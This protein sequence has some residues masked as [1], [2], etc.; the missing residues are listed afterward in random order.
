M[1]EAPT[2]FSGSVPENYHR[3]L[4][5]LIFEYYATD[6]A[7]RLL[8]RVPDAGA[9]LETACGTGVLTGL[10]A[11]AMPTGARLYATDLNPA[12][13]GVA[14][15]NLANHPSRERLTLQPADATAL[16][17]NNATFDALACQFGVMFY[18][19]KSL[20]YT[21]AARVL[22]PGGTL[23]FNVW[24][25][26]EHND[27]CQMTHRIAVD[28]FPDNPPAFLEV[29]FHY[30][31]LNTIRADLHAAGFSHIDFHILPATSAAPTPR[32]AA[33]ALVAGTPLAM[34][35]TGEGQLQAVLDAVQN[36]LTERFSQ[37]PVEAPMRAITIVATREA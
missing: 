28:M 26:L 2:A 22:K 37:G 35:L 9:I 30:Q 8:T 32:D 5:P 15:T 17:F 23:A 27:L 33:M 34:Q 18:P 31:D 4:A 3:Y 7:A 20:G 29:P 12:M 11:N 10:L 13:L 6:L 1:S 16:P 21:E 14:E 25:S 24:D 19:D 36:A